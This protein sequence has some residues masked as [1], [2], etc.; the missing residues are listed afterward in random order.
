MN[1]Q[2]FFLLNCWTFFSQ[3]GKVSNNGQSNNVDRPVNEKLI[4]DSAVKKA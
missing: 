4:L 1:M 2:S 3:H